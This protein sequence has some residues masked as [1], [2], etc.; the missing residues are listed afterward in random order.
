MKRIITLGLAAAMLCGASMSAEAA[1]IKV[2]GM[3]QMTGVYENHL[4]LVNDDAVNSAP[5]S[6]EDISDFSVKHRLHVNMNIVNSENLMANIGFMAPILGEW[7]QGPLAVGGG[8]LGIHLLRAYIDWY[9]P[10]TKVKIRMGMQPNLRPN[11]LDMNTNPHF[12]HFAPGVMVE[13]PINQM[14]TFQAQWLRLVDTTFLGTNNSVSADYF[15]VNLPIKFDG[16]MVTPWASYMLKHE[17]VDVPVP[18]R[19]NGVGDNTYWVGLT[20]KFTMF[21]PFTLNFDFMYSSA[22]SDNADPTTHYNTVN[23]DG[24]GWLVDG[25]IAYR[26]KYGSTK[27]SAWYSPGADKDGDNGHFGEIIS[28][29]VSPSA[30]FYQ[31][32]FTATALLPSSGAGSPNGT[33][34]IMLGHTGLEL[35]KNWHI[36]GHVMY[37]HGTHHKNSITPG[38]TFEP[39]HLTTEDS[40]VEFSLWTRHQIMKGLTSSFEVNYIMENFDEDVWFT[41]GSGAKFEDGFRTNLSFFYT[42]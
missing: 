31:D 16:G 15:T 23:Y 21:D 36:G 41:P 8:E 1:E 12:N 2:N 42:F 18:S 35:A 5:G 26:S 14:F 38:T 6:R 22:N 13:A 30:F 9:I 11:Y 17:D 37:L 32:L 25:S 39:N 19:L 34:G 40:L 7:G 28:T 20:S 10:T 3:W 4:G 29:W 33:W 27:L 24:Y